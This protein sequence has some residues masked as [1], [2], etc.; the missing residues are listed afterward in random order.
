MLFRSPFRTVPFLSVV[1]VVIGCVLFGAT[2]TGPLTPGA[3]NTM[4]TGGH[5]E[6]KPAE[7]PAFEIF[8]VITVDPGCCAVATPFWSIVTMELLCATYERCPT[9]QLIL[10]A[11]VWDAF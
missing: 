5:V 4:L 9:L 7:L 11:A 1:V 3:L 6:K 2:E 10:F 8:A